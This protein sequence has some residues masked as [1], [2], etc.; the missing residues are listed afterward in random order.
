MKTK[1]SA[2]EKSQRHAATFNRLS[3][4]ELTSVAGGRKAGGT[5]AFLVYTLNNAY[6]TSIH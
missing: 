5:Q 2:E 3:D 4:E 6:V 1:S